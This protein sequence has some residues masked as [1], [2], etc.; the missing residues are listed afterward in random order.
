MK[1]HLGLVARFCLLFVAILH[2]GEAIDCFKCVSFGGN[3]KPCDDPFHNNGSFDFLESPCLG[4]RK[5]RDG[6]FPATACIKLAGT[7]V[8][9][10]VSFTVR[11]CALDSGT[12]TTDSEITRMSHC[13]H[14]YLDNEYAEGCVQ[15]CN[16]ADACNASRRE[17]ISMFLL[18]PPIFLGCLLV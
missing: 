8:D 10:G 4:G 9:S 3:N 2:G 5:G 18:I 14:F 13:G 7:Y 16:D 1:N 17:T 11:S 6:L 15:S 12:L